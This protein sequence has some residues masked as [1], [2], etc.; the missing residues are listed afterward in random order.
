MGSTK[1]KKRAPKRRQHGTGSVY[2]RPKGRW[3]IRWYEGGARRYASGFVSEAQ[4]R[5]ALTKILGDV[6][7]GRVGLPLD[8]GPILD[9]EKHADDWLDRRDETHRS[10]KEDR[11]RW[12]KHL[13]PWFGRL[14][15]D[16]IDPARLRRFI[17]AKRGEGLSPSTVRLCV[18]TLSGLFSDLV[19]RGLSQR[20]PV[21]DLPRDTRKLIKSAH[22][23][24]TTPFLERLE[25]VRRVFLALAEPVN[26]A[27]ALGAMAGLRTGE[28]LGLRWEH[29]DLAARRLHVRESVTGRLKDDD[30]RAVPILDGLSPILAAWKLATGGTGRVIPPMRS[31]GEACD[32]HT[33]R[34]HL[35]AALADLKLPSVTW[36][37][38]TRHTFAS[39]WVLSGGTLE[40]LRELM[41]HSTVIVTERYS[42]LKLDLFADADLGRIAVDLRPT[43][44]KVVGEI[45]CSTGAAGELVQEDA[46]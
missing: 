15:P 13:K 7:A 12:G 29:V 35:K 16:A 42:H 24:R 41:G 34:R 4:A 9:L 43:G 32:D 25:D 27:F 36:Y 10:A 23:P 45:G 8:K 17:E 44:G 31:D 30:S 40:K 1:K 14:K 2:E 21:R 22:D 18:L 37:Q 5:Q 3:R 46:G 28:V 39:Q 6:A 26:V 38:A 33:L 11:W 20:H 19:E